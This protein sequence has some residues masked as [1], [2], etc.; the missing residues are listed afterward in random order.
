MWKSMTIYEL[1]DVLKEHQC[2][3]K[4]NDFCY[5][6]IFRTGKFNLYDYNAGILKVSIYLKHPQSSYNGLLSISTI[7]DGVW[8]ADLNKEDILDEQKAQSIIDIFES[9]EGVLPTE[10]EINFDLTKIGMFG[11]YT[12]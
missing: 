1:H 6:A 7:D 9:Y 5:S 3:K 10:E 12:G 2:F 4:Q 11:I 8:Q